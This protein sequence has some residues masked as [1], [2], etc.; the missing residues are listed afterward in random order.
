MG[1]VTPRGMHRARKSEPQG[2]WRN[3]PQ[4]RV[5]CRGLVLV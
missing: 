3:V 5:G 1:M 4:Q 2:N